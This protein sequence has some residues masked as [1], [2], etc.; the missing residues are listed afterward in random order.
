[1]ATASGMPRVQL[2]RL[3]GTALSYARDITKPD[4]TLYASRPT[5]ATP[6][7]RYIWRLVVYMVS[8][9][10]QHQCMPVTAWFELGPYTKV[11][12]LLDE[13]DAIADQIIDA[14][15]VHQWHSV[16][17]WGRVLGSV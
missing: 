14:V 6:E 7:A 12:G 13:L 15:P 5:K 10:P 8:P 9:R 1:M 11:K 17:Q 16:A 2:D 4:G 3:S